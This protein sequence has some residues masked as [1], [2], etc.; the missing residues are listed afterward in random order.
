[1]IRI[2][3]S[4]LRKPHKVGKAR[5]LHKLV[6]LCK[7]LKPLPPTPVCASAKSTSALSIGF[8]AP[9]RSQVQILRVSCAKIIKCKTNACQEK[10][11]ET[12]PRR[13]SGKITE[14]F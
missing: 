6:K 1:M 11:S 10:I 12:H 8:P 13:A 14:N 7:P 4:K 2:Q 9:V 5:K 3:R